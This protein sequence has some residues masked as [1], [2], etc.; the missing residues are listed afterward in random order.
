MQTRRRE[1]F[2]TIRSE[3]AILPPDLIQ[4]AAGGDKGLEGLTPEDYHLAAG[5]RLN[6]A[7]TRS[8]NRLVGAWAGFRDAREKVTGD[9]PGTT[10]TRERWLLIL[11]EEL[12]Y[13]RLQT[14][15]AVELDGKSYPVSHA[16]GNVPIHLVGFGVPL[17]KRT[18]RVAGAASHSPHGLVQEFLNRSD[19]RL[20]GFVSNGL[21]LRIL[22]DSSTLTRQ[23][24]VEFDLEAMME[25]E[26]YADFAVLWLLC[27]VS[28]VEAE[29]PDECWL[30]RWSQAAAKQGT[31][32]LEGLRQGVEAAIGA[33]G[34]GF[35]AHPAN[36]DLRERLRTGQLSTQDYYRQLLRLVYRLLFLFVA[37]DR[38]LLFDPRADAAARER[39]ER[40]YST[41]RLRRLAER[42]RGSK[43][44]DLF[45]ALRLVMAKLGDDEGCTGLGLPP[46]GSF[47]WSREATPGLDGAELANADLLGAVRALSLLEERGV[48][49]AVDYKNLGAE[50]LGSVYESLLELHPELNVD[51]ATFGL[52]T[53][54]GHERKTTGS[55]YTPSSLI[56]C[57]LDSALD[58]VLDEAA[59]AEDPEQAILNLKVCDPACGSGHFLVAAAHRIA[60]RLAAAR[61]GDEEPSP[62][63]TRA[64]LRDVIGHCVYGVDVNPMAVE[65]CKV[66]L[67]MEALDPGRPLSF[68]DAHIKCGNSLLG[69]TPELLG[70]GI[71]DDAFKPIEGDEKEAA[72]ELKKDNRRERS[73]QLT[74]DEAVGM[75]ETTLGEKAAQIEAALDD[76]IGSLHQKEKRFRDLV[77]SAEYGRAKLLADAW[78]AAFVQRKMKGAP[79]RVTD[80]LLR[81]LVDAS[82]EVAVNTR[83][84]ITKIADEYRF[85]QWHVEFPAVF[86]R[87]DGGFDVV[88]GNPPWERVKLQEKEFFAETHPE[89]AAAPNKAARERLIERL[90][91]E[92]PS[93]YA[94]FRAALR[95]ADGESHLVRNSGRYPLCG[96]GDV[97]T[98]SIFAELMRL[99]I[100]PTGRVGCIVPLGIATDDTTKHFFGDLVERRSLVSLFGFENEEFIFPG[101][102]HRVS[103]SLLTLTGADRP[104]SAAEFAFF[105]REVTALADPERRF[106]LAPEDFALLNPNT[107]TCPIFRSRRD[108]ELTKRIYERVP[109]LVDES[110]GEDGNPWGVKFMAMFHMANDS[111]LFRTADEL[112]TEGWRLDGNVFRNGDD[113]YRP[114]YEAKMV[115]HFNHRFGTYEG[116]TE[117]QANQ[118]KLPELGSEQLE[119]PQLEPL[120]RYWVA[121]ADID[122]ALHDK[123]DRGWLL[124]WRD[125]CRSTDERT[126]ISGVIPWAAAG[127]TF[128]LA[129]LGTATELAG[130]FNASLD[131]LVLDYVARQ[132][133]G[134]THMKYHVFKQVAVLP[135][136]TYR[137]AL[138]W[139]PLERVGDW[140]SSR[141]LE[142]IYTAWDVEPFARDLD[143]DGPPFRWD[144]ARR[145][146]LRAELDAAFFHLYGLERDDVDYVM[147]TFWVVRDRDVRAHGEYRTK[148]VILEIYDEMAEAVAPGRR[149]QTRLDPP[150]ADPRVAHPPQSK[151]VKASA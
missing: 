9:D 148:R 140:I 34:T 77:S 5:E 84:A 66:S 129:F 96:R 91:V 30:E 67:W 118:G 104:A 2:T 3:G 68:L 13:G 80:S 144:S 89:I 49:R 12:R 37:E 61:T 1:L 29:R 133:L 131:S 105:A 69:T 56:N 87:E 135:P 98:Y 48:R 74:L 102:D 41:Q 60:K 137:H 27:H 142:L 85:F 16:W 90:A 26:V 141:A 125:I 59:S 111:G 53:A 25:G 65:L 7:M 136:A 52:T 62:E 132:K 22:R 23:A 114:L 64:A 73:G 107:R 112:E 33:L 151:T 79:L 42:R 94:A 100:S 138:S 44:A 122:A 11:F 83:D 36:R 63:A 24:Y 54:S 86:D 70:A 93:A 45:Q 139:S 76:S 126:V 130:C 108:A 134:G 28:R 146:L 95:R 123:W 147:D 150:P 81:G 99:A 58:P 124:G 17:D 50:E 18:A 6:E 32:V 117:A 19:E 101:I 121:A 92:D 82:V 14:A 21:T 78:C 57:L 115:H 128:L 116:Q 110:R 120:P 38:A 8:W 143:Y 4:R 46:L 109:V 119:D 31:R 88:L 51:A 113:S 39:Y 55:Y 20:W 145:F 47:L 127:D 103:F 149:C 106:T 35:L 43:H 40:H 71:P 10:V 15:R 97:N 75:L 72:S